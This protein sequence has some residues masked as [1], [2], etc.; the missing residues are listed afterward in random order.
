MSKYILTFSRIWHVCVWEIKKKILNV[1]KCYSLYYLLC[2]IISISAY[3]EELFLDYYQ[4]DVHEV[5]KSIPTMTD[6]ENFSE[7]LK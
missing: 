3:K 4:V 2:L 6:L 5:L 7:F 1:L